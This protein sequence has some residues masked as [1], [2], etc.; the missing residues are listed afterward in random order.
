[1]G[2]PW[3]LDGIPTIP[4]MMGLLAASRTDTPTAAR[5]AVAALPAAVNMGWGEIRSATTR[6][7]YPAEDGQTPSDQA[8]D[9]QATD[10]QATDHQARA[11]PGAVPSTG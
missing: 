7:A 9:H 2:V 4:A 10:H 1:M 6:P 5:F 8:A 11:A 3:L